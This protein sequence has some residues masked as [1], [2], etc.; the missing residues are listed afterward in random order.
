[1]KVPK[2]HRAQLRARAEVP[3]GV[4]L[5]ALA[6]G[7]VYTPSADHKDHWMDGLQPRLRSDATP[8]PRSVTKEQAEVWL[9]EAMAAGNIGEPWDG[10]SYPRMV[11]ASVGDCTF[12]ARLSNDEQ[13]WYH[14]Y[15]IDESERP[16][17]L[18]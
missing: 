16:K 7:A 2:R 4:D 10:Q 9:K 14:G 18:L 3:S 17:W 12:E 15:P 11:W 13:G 1:M 6:D 5:Q 8:C